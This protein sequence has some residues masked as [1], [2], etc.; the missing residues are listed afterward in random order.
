MHCPRFFTA[1]EV[2]SGTFSS[3]LW[4]C[5]LSRLLGI[6]GLVGLY[7][8][9]LPN[10]IKAQNAALVALKKISF[11]VSRAFT[12]SNHGSF[13]LLTYAPFNQKKFN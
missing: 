6:F 5:T 8:H 4:Q 12:N 11:F 13:T 7:H 9:Q 2:R 3:P 1:A 10:T